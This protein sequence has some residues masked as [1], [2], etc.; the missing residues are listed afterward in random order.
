MR[1]THALKAR[2]YHCMEQDSK[3]AAHAV[4]MWGGMPLPRVIKLCG[5][6]DPKTNNTLG[7][8]LSSK[9]VFCWE[10]NESKHTKLT[11]N[12]YALRPKDPHGFILY[13]RGEQF[14]G[15]ALTSKKDAPH[16]CL[17]SLS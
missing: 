4:S 7:W 16:S 14:L 10:R 15:L 13:K 11:S 12:L 6:F 8:A 1:L 2:V 3:T 5:F 17:I 9:S